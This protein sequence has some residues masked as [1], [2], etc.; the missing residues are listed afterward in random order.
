ME[1]RAGAPPS[2]MGL[3]EKNA[4]GGGGWGR[5][6]AKSLHAR[7]CPQLHAAAACVPLTVPQL[8]ARHCIAVVAADADEHARRGTAYWTDVCGRRGLG[9]VGVRTRDERV[10]E[11]TKDE[12]P[13]YAEAASVGGPLNRRSRHHCPH[14]SLHDSL[15]KRRDRHTHTHR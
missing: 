3:R 11:R 12:A 15:T 1:A 13:N 5:E 14:H 10:G 6:R 4:M 9:M 2:A 8:D 7:G